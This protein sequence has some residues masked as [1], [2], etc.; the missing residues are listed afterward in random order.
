[1]KRSQLRWNNW[2]YSYF[3]VRA[4]IPR[5]LWFRI[6]T[7]KKM[8]LHFTIRQD[9]IKTIRMMVLMRNV[10]N[11]HKQE[12]TK[13]VI[14][15]Q[16]HWRNVQNALGRDCLRL[17]P[18]ALKQSVYSKKNYFQTFSMFPFVNKTHC[19]FSVRLGKVKTASVG[20]MKCVCEQ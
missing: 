7:D 15:E 18:L 12:N 14:K 19:V 20:V 3:H 1:M 13:D 16:N 17:K 4:Q 2:F 9:K 11:I 5:P 10:N 6:W 8:N